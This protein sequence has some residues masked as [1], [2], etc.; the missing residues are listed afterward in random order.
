MRDDIL[1]EAGHVFL[2][3]RL[4]R[5]A[6]RLQADAGRIVRSEGFDFLPSQ[7]TLLAA[8]DRYGPLT[9]GQA[10]EVMGLSQPAITRSMA[11]LAGQ[12]LIETEQ[13]TADRR[14]KVIQ[15]TKRGADTFARAQ[16]AIWPRMGAA[17][18]SL[19]AGAS[20]S[21]IEQIADLERELSRVPLDRRFAEVAMP[22]EGLEI[23]EY[24]KP[25]AGLFHDINAEWIEAMF[26][27]EDADRETL[28][29]PDEKIIAPGGV[30]LFV[31]ASGLGIVGTCALLKSGEGRF[32]LTKMG[33]LES[34]RGRKAG[35]FLLAQMIGRAR[36]MDVRELYLLTNTKC[37]AAIHLYEKAGF[38]HDP[39]IME[40]YGKRYERCDVAMRF[41][42]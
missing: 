40:R 35:E 29:H 11:G 39:D 26:A 23:V 38:V 24:A 2:G 1:A 6:E 32:E 33:V 36:V 30:I 37:A 5:L 27:M 28:E 34:A 17:V 8:I 3:S 31:K 21:L 20:G 19:C 14:Q 13:S 10:V 16:A 42:L 18:Q 22:G 4:K 12:G 15:L 25:L 41:P 9:V 7:F